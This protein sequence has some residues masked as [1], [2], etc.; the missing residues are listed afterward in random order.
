M[1]AAFG[2]QDYAPVVVRKKKGSKGG[3]AGAGGPAGYTRSHEAKVEEAAASNKAAHKKFDAAFVKAVVQAR[4]AKGWDQAALARHLSLDRQTV[5]K[6]EAG[7]LEFRGNLKSTLSNFL[8]RSGVA[9][10]K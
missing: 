2:H 1:N 9:W 4:L 8:Q 7:K 6:F 10:K 5:R 3:K